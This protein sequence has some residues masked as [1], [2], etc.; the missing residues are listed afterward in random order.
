MFKLYMM[1]LTEKKFLKPKYVA[2]VNVWNI[3]NILQCFK[4]KKN[5]GYIEHVIFVFKN[6]LRGIV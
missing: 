3:E 2:V 5:N 4:D 6:I 1:L